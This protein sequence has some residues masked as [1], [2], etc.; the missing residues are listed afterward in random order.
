M[1]QSTKINALSRKA[2]HRKSMLANMASSLIKHKRINT[3]IAKAKV[4]RVFIEPLITRSK[5]DTTHSRRMVFSHLKDK[6]AVAEL[7]RD[8]APKVATRPGGYTRILK[9]GYRPGDS[10]EMCFIELV[11]FNT[12]YTSEKQTKAAKVRTR[13]GRTKKKTEQTAI[14]ITPGSKQGDLQTDAT[15]NISSKKEENKSE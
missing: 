1:A 10:S 6:H 12:T 11:D 13:R 3:T 2:G 9:T 8:V 15:N 7:F 5:S 14:T 4:L